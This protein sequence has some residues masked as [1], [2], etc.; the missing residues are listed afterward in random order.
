M[1]KETE[2]KKANEI[3]QEAMETVNENMKKSM[4]EYVKMGTEVQ[5]EIFTLAHQQM[6]SYRKLTSQALEQ[7]QNF[8]AQFEKNAKH[9]RDLWLK[10]LESWQ[11]VM[12]S[13]PK[14]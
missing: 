10:G 3:A 2:M 1:T 6:D 12:K 13:T 4:E 7:Q 14:A 11:N 5:D 8:F 9:S